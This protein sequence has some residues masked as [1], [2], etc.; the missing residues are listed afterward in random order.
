[1][2]HTTL[3]TRDLMDEE[4][5]WDKI[6]SGYDS[7]IFDVF[8][9]DR[10]GRLKGL[11]SKYGNAKHT[12]IDFG[13]GTG[14]ALP[15][16][17]PAFREVL[18]VDISSELIRQAK[19][20][21]YPNVTFRQADLTKPFRGTSADFAFCCNVI[22]LPEMDK[23]RR[24][25]RNIQKTLKPGG[26][27]VMVLPSL[28]S[29]FYSGLRLINWYGKEGI[30]P[31]DII[32]SEFDGFRAPKR[33]LIRGLVSIDGVITKHYSL[34]E[35]ELILPEAGFHVISIERLEY[36]W[37]TE[38]SKPPRWMKEPYPWDWVVVCSHVLAG[39]R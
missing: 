3:A 14:K 25:F 29:F 8:K 30:Q 31:K 36:E 18:A 16:L 24:M 32:A 33:D 28:D 4:R 10:L 12:A 23:N 38:F 19:G 15:Y 22:M 9:S 35:L 6:G 13:C 26:T 21:G 37:T 39:L 2:P 20:R 17:A 34:P 27:A 7:E 11:F 5:H 1:M